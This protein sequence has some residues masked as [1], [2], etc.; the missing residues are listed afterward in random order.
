MV[1]P[2]MPRIHFTASEVP[3]D[4][5]SSGAKFRVLKKDDRAADP[6]HGADLAAMPR[7]DAS[8]MLKV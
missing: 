2:K 6:P 3:E 1:A 8:L 4:D 7:N 5:V